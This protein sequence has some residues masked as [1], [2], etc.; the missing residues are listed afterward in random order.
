MLGAWIGSL[1]HLVVRKHVKV[2]GP[3]ALTSAAYTNQFEEVKS[4][5]RATGSEAHGRSDADG[6]VLQLQRGHDGQ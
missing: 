3:D 2:D 5:G 6:A 1:R 4:L